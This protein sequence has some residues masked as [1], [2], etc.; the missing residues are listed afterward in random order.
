[1]PRVES[2]T[3]SFGTILRSP[4]GH[5][6]AVL[7][8]NI[9]WSFGI[10]LCVTSVQILHD[11]SVQFIRAVVTTFVHNLNAFTYLK[12]SIKRNLNNQDPMVIKR[13]LNNQDPMADYNRSRSNGGGMMQVDTYHEPRQKSSAS[14]HDFRSWSFGDPAFQRKKRVASYKMYGAEGSQIKAM[15][16]QIKSQQR[17][18]E[19]D[20]QTI[21]SPTQHLQVQARLQ[22]LPPPQLKA[23]A[24]LP[25]DLRRQRAGRISSLTVIASS[26]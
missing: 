24:L 13:N 10:F 16:A 4:S 25:L 14:N 9:M 23:N 21:E 18:E 19:N 2:S 5:F 6:N 22:P 1:M 15:L 17:Q 11:T 3:R 8:D 7:R 12:F 26:L 20:Q